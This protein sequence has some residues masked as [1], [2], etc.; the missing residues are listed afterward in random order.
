[1]TIAIYVF[2][3]QASKTKL[4]AIYSR[5][6]KVTVLVIK[7]ALHQHITAVSRS[8]STLDN[9]LVKDTDIVEAT[10]RRLVT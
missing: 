9:K 1:M 4:P 10:T 3:F 7:H 8:Y 2:A 6:R 5:S